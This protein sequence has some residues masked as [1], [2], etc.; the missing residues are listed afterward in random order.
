MFKIHGITD[1]FELFQD[2]Y[3]K[4]LLERLKKIIQLV[5][6]ACFITFQFAASY[7]N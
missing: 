4:K 3:N 2:F 1:K 7:F 6:T 5:I